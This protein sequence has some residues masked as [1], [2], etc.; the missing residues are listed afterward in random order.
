MQWIKER[1]IVVES[2]HPN[3]LPEGEG[4]HSSYK[5]IFEVYLTNYEVYLDNFDHHLT[6]SEVHLANFDYHLIN[7]EVRLDNFD[8]HL[9]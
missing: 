2:P 7:S 9:T 5:I 8:H 3:L 6:I 4:T 1:I